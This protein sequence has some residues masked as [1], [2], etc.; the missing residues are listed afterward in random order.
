MIDYQSFT[1]PGKTFFCAFYIIQ[2]KRK[3]LF[4]L[5]LIQVSFTLYAQVEHGVKKSVYVYFRQGEGDIDEAYMNNSAHLTYFVNQIKS[6]SKDSLTSCF[7]RI[8][9][10]ASPEGEKK[11]D[12]RLVKRRAESIAEWVA[13]KIKCNIKFDID[14][15]GID[16]NMLIENVEVDSVV[17]YRDEVLEILR[18]TPETV[19]V[20]GIEHQE[21]QKT[22]QKLRRGVP[23]RYLFKE[24]Y[25]KMRYAS[26]RCEMILTEITK[27]Q[28]VD[29]ITSTIKSVNSAEIPASSISMIDVPAISQKWHPKLHVKANALTYF[30]LLPNLALEFDF[31]KHWSVALPVYYSALNWFVHDVKFRTMAVQP[32]V[33]YWFN[34]ENTKWFIGAHFN[35]AQ[36]NI[37]LNGDYRYQDHIG[38]TPT[39]GGGLSAGYRMP[40]SRDNRWNVEFSLGVGALPLKYDRFYNVKNGRFADTNSGCYWGVDNANVSFSYSFEL[41]KKGGRK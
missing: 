20:N 33:R 35:Y 31:A 21:R 14:S 8:I 39:I 5:L 25:P 30:L 23:Y 3:L 36:Y 17:P 37:A 9:S 15:I 2:M 40:L 26:A 12:V 6:Y 32:E 16:W 7:I 27:L 24:L 22:L 13:D 4:I 1:P 41:K 34:S 19:V 11:S 29:D 18:T 28:P 38:K 10:S